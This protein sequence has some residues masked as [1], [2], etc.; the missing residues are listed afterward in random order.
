MRRRPSFLSQV[1]LGL[2]IALCVH[3]PAARAQFS[4]NVNSDVSATSLKQ[5]VELTKQTIQNIKMIQTQ[6][7]TRLEMIAEYVKQGSR[8][9]E[10]VQHYAAVV[11]S[12]VRRFTTLKGIMGFTEQQLGLN[13]DTLKAFAALNEIARGI[14][15]IRNQ[16][17]ALCTTRIRMWKNL[18]SRARAG[19]FNPRADLDDL[20]DYLT[21]SIGRSAQE[22]IATRE[23]L[24]Q[25]DNELESWTH[26]L[27]LKRAREAELQKQY[28][29]AVQFLTDEGALESRPRTV[30]QNTDGSAANSNPTAGRV[31]ASAEAIKEARDSMRWSDA[32]LSKVQKEI[33]DL[34]AKIEERYKK[35]HVKFDESLHAAEQVEESNQAWDD[36]M[37]I[38]NEV[39]LEMIEGFKG[40]T[41]PR[42]RPPRPKK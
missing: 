20:E 31:S 28:S 26:Q 3:M 10:T 9:L 5:V 39:A 2:L 18:A 13:E 25:F 21:N 16:F 37:S 24:A 36:F 12:N 8:W 19:I 35:Y 29:A 11:E 23:R 6:D 33:A 7:L 38:K 40:D 1:V 41:P 4:V 17:E 22:V 34:I 27:E 32:E 15:S 42:L 14:N 30:A